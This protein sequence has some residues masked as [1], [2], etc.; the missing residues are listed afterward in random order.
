M[1]LY[2]CLSN[3]RI[4]RIRGREFELWNSLG[5]IDRHSIEIY[6]EQKKNEGV[7]NEKVAELRISYMKNS[8]EQPLTKE[9]A[10]KHIKCCL[11]WATIQFPCLVEIY[12]D[13]L[14]SYCSEESVFDRPFM[15]WP[16]NSLRECRA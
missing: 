16:R 1:P 10:L 11:N 8:T 5:G 15:R 4:Q 14:S 13:G 9:E 3:E 2:M 6:A 12:I 7:Q